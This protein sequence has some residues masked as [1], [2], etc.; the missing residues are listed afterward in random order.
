M[1]GNESQVLRR[2][3]TQE[4]TRGGDERRALVKA[5]VEASDDPMDRGDLDGYADA[6]TRRGFGNPP[7]KWVWRTP[8]VRVSHEVMLTLS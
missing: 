5:T 8:R 7:E 6:W 3:E 4:R 1:Q 2:H